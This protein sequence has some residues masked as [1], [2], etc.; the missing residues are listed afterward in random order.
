[1]QQIR[2]SDGIV[3]ATASD[4]STLAM[5]QPA[6]SNVPHATDHPARALSPEQ[7]LQGQQEI[8]EMVAGGESLQSS[9]QAIAQ[10]SETCLPE[11]LASIL[12]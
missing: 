4:P 6:A 10:F 3:N 9:L 11:M 5:V 8:L 7:L 12:Y 2:S 1:M